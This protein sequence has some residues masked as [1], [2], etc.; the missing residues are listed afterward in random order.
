VGASAVDATRWRGRATARSSLKVATSR[1]SGVGAAMHGTGVVEGADGANGRCGGAPRGDMAI[2]PAVLALGVP[3]G[4]VRAF[5]SSRSGEETNRGAH[6]RH[7]PSVDGEDNRGGRLA[8]PGLCA[9]VEISGGE[10]AYGL[11]VEDRLR[12]TREELLQV[13]REE[14]KWEGVEGELC[15]VGGEAEGQPGGL[16]H[17]ERFVEL[18]GE[19]VEIWSEGRGGGGRV[20]D[21]KGD[22]SMVIDLGGDCKGED[23]VRIP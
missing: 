18:A 1:A 15:F 4:R 16:A 23:A 20:G 11:G 21:E 3:V 6:G 17:G 22:R 9:R 5:N 12:K 8:L 13:L 14:G 2:T 7:V 10:D 19:G